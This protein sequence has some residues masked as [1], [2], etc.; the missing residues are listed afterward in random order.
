MLIWERLFVERADAKE[1]VSDP[2]PVFLACS[3]TALVAGVVGWTMASISPGWMVPVC[4][5]VSI[6]AGLLGLRSSLRMVGLIGIVMGMFL[7]P[8]AV[9]TVDIYDSGTG[10]WSTDTL[11][12][13][14]G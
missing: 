4:S 8:N 9:N 13:S 6:L 5:G 10:E 14:R 3:V 1:F 12:Q 7:L 11:S 2:R